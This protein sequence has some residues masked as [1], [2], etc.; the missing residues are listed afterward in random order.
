MNI[1]LE[2]K[3]LAEV[4]SDALVIV[5]FDGAP[6][7]APAAEQTKELYDSGEFSG[8]ALEIA[9]L[10]RPAGPSPPLA[11][12]T[13]QVQRLQRG[14][15]SQY[16]HRTLADPASAERQTLESGEGREV[17]QATVGYSGISYVE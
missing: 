1:R 2:P 16:S 5:G 11:H 14:K 10:H 4:D 15:Q 7:A 9:I 6:P 8:K 13:A 12:R 3:Q 17:F